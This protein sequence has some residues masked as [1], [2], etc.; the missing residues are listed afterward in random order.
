M[1]QVLREKEA[2]RAA[3]FDENLSLLER[4]RAAAYFASQEQGAQVLLCSEIGSEGRN[5]QFANQLVMF[6]LP[7]NPDLLE[8]RIGRLDRI[9]QNRDIQISVPYLENTAQA[10]LLRWYHEALDAFEYTCPTG[11]AIYDQYYQQLVEYL[12][13]PTVLDNFDDFI[14]ACRAKHN[15]LKTELEEGRDRLLE[16]NSNDGE[17][18]QDLAKQIAEQDNSID[19]TNF[20]LNLFDIIGINQEDRRDNLIVLTPAE[21]MLIPDFPGLPQDGCSITFDRTQALSR[22]DTEFISWEHPII[23]NGMDLILSGEI[24]SCAVSLLKKKLTSRYTT[25]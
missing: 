22:E 17:I 8:Q 9:G 3:V 5:F 13:K 19:L 24:G 21:H 11:R 25:Y 7:F 14:K 18:G 16:M 10:I 23:R 4:D 12:A 6:D 1:E 15:K 2:I 20:S